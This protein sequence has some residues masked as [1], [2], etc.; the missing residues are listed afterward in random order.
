MI[1][2]ELK[3]FS[4]SASRKA[5]REVFLPSGLFAFLHEEVEDFDSMEADARKSCLMQEFSLQD[6]WEMAVRTRDLTAL[7]QITVPPVL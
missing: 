6:I 4:A 2:Q 3:E 7:T 1:K 5:A